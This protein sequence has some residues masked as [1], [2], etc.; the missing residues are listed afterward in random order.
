MHFHGSF[1]TRA[2]QNL[3]QSAPVFISSSLLQPPLHLSSIDVVEALLRTASSGEIEANGVAGKDA[4]SEG[5]PCLTALMYM[6]GGYW[7]G[8]MS[9]MHASS[10]QP[11]L[12]D[13]AA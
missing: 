12:H 3:S 1:A 13:T 6:L 7:L 2:T 10:L 4:F 8:P 5:Y 9:R 11:A